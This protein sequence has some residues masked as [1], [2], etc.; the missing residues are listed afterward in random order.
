MFFASR[1]IAKNRD[2]HAYRTEERGTERG[3]EKDKQRER[4]RSKTESKPNR[5]QNKPS[6]PST[7]LPDKQ[8]VVPSESSHSF[9]FLLLD[10]R[11]LGLRVEGLGFMVWRCLGVGVWDAPGDLWRHCQT[12]LMNLN[13]S[14]P[15]Y[16]KNPKPQ[17]LNPKPKT[18]NPEP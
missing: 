12:S 8:W 2:A 7:P 4:E 10:H 16:P 3:S 11:G 6:S 1:G 17:T 5:A 15:T 9:G 13:P 14:N 18:L